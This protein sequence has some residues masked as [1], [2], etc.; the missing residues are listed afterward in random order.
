MKKIDFKRPKYALPLIVLPF[1]FLFN[2][3][4]LET[5]P[6][7]KAKV[8]THALQEADQIITELPDAN[9]EK[10]D[11]NSKFGAGMEEHKHRTDYSAI[12]ELEEE[13]GEEKKYGSVYTDKEKRMLDSMNNAIL[14]GEKN[15]DFLEKV[16]QRRNVDRGRYTATRPATASRPRKTES[17]EQKE[18]RLFKEQMRYMDSLDKA[19][20]EPK[21]A[22]VAEEVKEN[23]PEPLAVRKTANPNTAYFNTVTDNSEDQFIKAILDEGLKVREGGRLTLYGVLINS[24]LCSKDSFSTLNLSFIKPLWMCLDILSRAMLIIT[25][26][27]RE[28]TM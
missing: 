26:P 28:R 9:L 3:V 14:T 15:G 5:F 11:I 1:T 16:E 24:L 4:Y 10:K 21:R 8:T 13:G 18:M 19:G 27:T 22:A 25:A 7:A 6:P 2:Y 23:L 20:R 12:R 17:A